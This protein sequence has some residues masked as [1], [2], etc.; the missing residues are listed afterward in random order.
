MQ[1]NPL[2]DVSRGAAEAGDQATAE[3]GPASAPS[4][5]VDSPRALFESRVYGNP[6]SARQKVAVLPDGG[7]VVAWAGEQSDDTDTGVRAREF[8]KRGVPAGEQFLV[9][10]GTAGTQTFPGVG[11]SRDSFVIS[12][13]T[14]VSGND[15]IAVRR[16]RRV[17][18]FTDDFES[19]DDS[20]WSD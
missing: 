6:A 2:R 15:D 8:T 19:G 1:V 4:V 3:P 9:N 7:F 11:L 17:V 13:S 12:F 20:S 10:E 5:Q 18:V 16:F 14:E